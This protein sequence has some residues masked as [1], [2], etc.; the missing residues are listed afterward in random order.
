MSG[1]LEMERGSFPRMSKWEEYKAK[2]GTT[3]PWDVLV[4]DNR[5][6]DETVSAKRYEICE[7][8]PRFFKA[9]KQCKECGCFMVIKTKLK[10]AQ[11]PLQKW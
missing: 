11:C 7:A 4:A 5:N 8:C 10:E 3:R 6:F 1:G 2:V 9:T